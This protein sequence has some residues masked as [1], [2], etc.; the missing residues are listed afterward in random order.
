[1]KQLIMKDIRLV[2]ILNLVIVGIGIMGGFIGL[3]LEENFKSNY[4][5]AFVMIVI[6]FLVN[7]S[8]VTKES[9][10]R[11][12]SLIMSLPVNKFDIIKARY[13]TM[14]IYIFGILGIIYLTSN[15]GKLLF[16]SMQGSPL[17]LVGILTISSI[18]IIFLS[19]YL[20]FQYYDSKNAQM[21][22]S[23]LYMIIILLP[24]I[25]KNLNIDINDLGFVENLLKM[26]FGSIGFI[27]FGLG[28]AF[29][30]VSTF[31]SKGIYEGKEF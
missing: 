27:V 23:I 2:G 19:F 14:I 1:M 24:N 12:D 31:V 15:I 30:I 6:L 8:I 26:D 18:F 25:L 20:P 5:Y 21:F 7:T 22:S 9:K 11:P 16:S 3:F 28:L 13:L 29:Y 17:D 10:S 4:A